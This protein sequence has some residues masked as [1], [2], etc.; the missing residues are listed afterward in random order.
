MA[1]HQGE[2]VQTDCSVCSKGSDNFAINDLANPISE[3][4]IPFKNSNI[5]S[6]EIDNQANTDAHRPIAI[7]NNVSNCPESSEGTIENRD[8]DNNPAK[9]VDKNMEKNH[10]LT[11]SPTIRGVVVNDESNTKVCIVESLAS[12]ID[13]SIEECLKVIHS[14]N[15]PFVSSYPQ[16]EEL[17]LMDNRDLFTPTKRKNRRSLFK[18]MIRNCSNL[19]NRK[20]NECCAKLLNWTEKLVSTS[21]LPSSSNIKR[22]L[23]EIGIPQ[24]SLD[25]KLIGYVAISVHC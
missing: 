7:M 20:C 6:S 4:E 3:E 23:E 12:V 15:A 2:D 1:I 10:S 11:E 13:S 18:L 16:V 22:K 14:S 5:D 19:D 8:T 25:E 17:Q 9:S 24:C 21:I